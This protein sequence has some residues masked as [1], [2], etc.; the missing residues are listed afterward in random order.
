MRIHTHIT[1]VA[2]PIVSQM[3]LIKFFFFLIPVTH[4]GHFLW[5]RLSVLRLCNTSVTFVLWPSSRRGCGTRGSPRVPGT[6][7]SSAAGSEP[8]G[9]LGTANSEAVTML[10]KFYRKKI[11]FR[12]IKED[13]CTFLKVYLYVLSICVTIFIIWRKLQ[14]KNCRNSATS[15]P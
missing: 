5:L 7:H 8:G 13:N 15:N 14:Y 2:F 3:S 4:L 12:K 9:V 6:G 1:A 10:H 11:Q